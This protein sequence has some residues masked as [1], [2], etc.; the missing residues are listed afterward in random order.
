MFPLLSTIHGTP[1][2]GEIGAN[3]VAIPQVLCHEELA[4]E[5]D[6]NPQENVN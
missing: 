5:W 2:S 4:G 3:L 1:K 6:S